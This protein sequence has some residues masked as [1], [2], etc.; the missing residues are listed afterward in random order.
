M[1]IGKQKLY[2]IFVSLH[3]DI[4]KTLMAQFCPSGEKEP[5]F[6]PL[7]GSIRETIDEKYYKIIKEQPQDEELEKEEKEKKADSFWRGD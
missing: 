7:M 1:K 4:E 6:D 3:K 2:E 5:F